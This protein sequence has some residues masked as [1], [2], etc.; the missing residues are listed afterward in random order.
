MSKKEYSWTYLLLLILAGEAVFI[1][2]FI[3]QRVFRATVLDVFQINNTELG[4]CFT[5]YGLVALGSYFFGGPLADKHEPR[6]LIAIA[7]WATAL[8]G[9]VYALFPGFFVLQLL[10]AYWG[11][12]TIFLFW[13]PMLKATRM[14]GGKD[15]QCRA[16]GFLDGGRGAVGVL[17]SLIALG[18][19]ATGLSEIADVGLADQRRAFRQAILISSG[20]VAIIGC[21]IWLFM[22][23]PK[24]VDT[25][26]HIRA[27]DVLKVLKLP[28]VG[29]LMIIVMCAYVGYK[30]TDTVSLYAKDV[31]DYDEV[32][33][34]QI[35]TFM[36]FIRP[37]AGILIGLLADRMKPLRLLIGSFVV[38]MTGGIWFA[39]GWGHQVW[40]VFLPSVLVI[41]IGIFAARA[42]YFAVQQQGNIPLQ[43]SG[44]AVGL[45]SV[46]G[47]T[48]DI[49]AGVMIGAVLDGNPGPTG[50]SYVFMLLTLFAFIGMLASIR[51]AQINKKG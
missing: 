2:P 28:A 5:A 38:M 22:R 11:F 9:G 8:G 14:W 35:G 13:S 37:V 33:S 39:L 1:L 42:L 12:T 34:A 10:Y 6:K 30:S 51:Y 19:F 4:L 24:T 23:S 27:G 49:F 29:L 45:I 18:V 16:F 47:F 48:P 21:C 17:I 31:L 36:L 15:N 3:L 46:I 44:T 25:L 43:F 50:H 20:L 41:A 40:L 26:E 32:Q 7:L